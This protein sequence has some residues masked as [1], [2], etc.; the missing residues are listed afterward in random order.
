MPIPLTNN[1]PT[2]LVRREAFE[3][4]GLSRASIDQALTLTDDEF[5]VERDLVVIG[6]IY[7]DDGLTALVRAF[8]D[9][10][11]VYYDDFFEMSGNWPDWLS[12]LTASRAA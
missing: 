3:S 5:R 7:S 1:A 10:G 4:A 11:L 9:S 6:P 8:E 2:L 12:L